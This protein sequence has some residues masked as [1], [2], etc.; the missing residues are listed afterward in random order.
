VELEAMEAGWMHPQSAAPFNGPSP[1]WLARHSLWQD[2]DWWRAFVRRGQVHHHDPFY[3]GSG[4][5]HLSIH[6]GR[7]DQRPSAS[8]I[9]HIDARG[10]RAILI[11]EGLQCWL[12]GPVSPQPQDGSL[13]HGQARR[14]RSGS[15][16][17][18]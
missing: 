13:V 14:T 1:T 8:P 15:W 11:T 2:E 5:L 4:P 6:T 16:H 18:S 10:R 7:E 12:A 17:E 3:G 9:V